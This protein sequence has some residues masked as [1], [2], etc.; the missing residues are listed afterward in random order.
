MIR[1]LITIISIFF[2]ISC[3][4]QATLSSSSPEKTNHIELKGVKSSSLDPWII[5]LIAKGQNISK[6]FTLEIFQSEL[7]QE[8]IQFNWDS[9]SSAIITIKSQ[10]NV[11]HHFMVIFNDTNIVLTEN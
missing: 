5:D 1:S 10:D 4:S 2:F 8:T 11:T 7:N 3:G 6:T 9:E